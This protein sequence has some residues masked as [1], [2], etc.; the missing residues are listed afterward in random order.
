MRLPDF[1][2]FKEWEHEF[3]QFVAQGSLPNL[4]LIELPHDHFGSFGS[5]LD[6]VNTPDTQMADNDYALGVIVE[7]VARSPFADDTLIFV[8][9]DDAQDGPDHVDAQRTV[10]YVMGPY[11]KKGAVVS[12]HYSNANMLRTIVD[13][14]K[15]E[16]MGLQVA[17]AEPMTDV[18]DRAERSSTY[19]AI[20]PEVLRTTEL[21]LPAATVANSLP[22]TDRVKRFSAPRHNAEYWTTVMG[23]QDFNRMDNLDTN[24]FNRVLWDGLVGPGVPYPT[25]RHGRQMSNGRASLLRTTGATRAN[26]PVSQ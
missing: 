22:L 2:R 21:P 15:M 19:T 18:F 10:A 11:V 1:W 7:K 6:G 12:T 20:I 17:L 13:I 3:D 4:T 26:S 5:A 16:P 24:R 14:L 23:E 8:I 25:E 9:E